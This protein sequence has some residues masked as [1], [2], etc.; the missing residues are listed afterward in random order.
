MFVFVS[1]CTDKLV[2]KSTQCE[3]GWF[4]WRGYCYNLYGT[5][6]VERKSHAEAQQ[7]CVKNGAQLTSIHTLEEMHMLTMH[8]TGSRHNLR[9]F[10][11][12]IPTSYRF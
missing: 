6:M 2:Y 8:F 5:Q 3:S 7:V 1:L 10:P 12:D 11:T 4:A 9:S